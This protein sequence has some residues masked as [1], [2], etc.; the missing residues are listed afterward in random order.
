[1]PMKIS[2]EVWDA[3]REFG[4]FFVM[5]NPE[6]FDLDESDIAQILWEMPE[7]KIKREFLLLE[8]I[9]LEKKGGGGG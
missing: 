7:E 2:K 1:M 5:K 4:M 8:T 3:I 6:R 9:T